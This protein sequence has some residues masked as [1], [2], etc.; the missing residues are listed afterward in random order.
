MGSGFRGLR[1]EGCKVSCVQAAD[2]RVYAQ[3]VFLE[4]DPLQG[5]LNFRACLSYWTLTPNPRHVVNY[6]NTWVLGSGGFRK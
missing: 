3:K 1:F 4:A 6:W 5:S 2:F